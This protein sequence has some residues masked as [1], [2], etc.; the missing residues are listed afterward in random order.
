MVFSLR[1]GKVKISVILPTNRPLGP[2]YALNGLSKQTFPQ[3]DF[4]LIIV[5]DYPED[6]SGVITD[7]SELLGLEKVSV[8]KSKGNYW[9]SNRLISNAR[10]TGLIHAKGE[11]VAFLDDY[12]W[13]RPRWLEEHWKTYRRKA[14]T[15]IGAMQA[16]KYIPHRVDSL[17]ELPPLDI[18]KEGWKSRIDLMDWI[19]EDQKERANQLETYG[20]KDTRGQKPKRNCGGGWFYTCN[21]SAPLEKIIEVNGFDEQFDTC[22]E[23]DI[24]LGLRLERA[25]CKFFYRPEPDC[26]VYHMDHREVDREMKKLPKRYVEV[27]YEELRR[28]GAV[29]SNLD[30]VQLVLKEKYGT[31][32]DGSWGLHERNYRNRGPANVVNGKRIFDLRGE[33]RKL[34]NA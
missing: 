23:E 2:M 29:E 27:T 6:R 11:L 20:S 10:N 22:S 18:D 4:E 34:R 19:T 8:L 13:I 9:R 21:A 24:D 25:G 30:E 12:C 33:R 28:R 5:D 26:T 16:V 15:M 3:E 7:T 17:D 1:G 32:F 14:Y 31:R